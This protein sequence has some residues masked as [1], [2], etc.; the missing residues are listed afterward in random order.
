[1][2]TR[3]VQ[4]ADAFYALGDAWGEL[5]DRAEGQRVFLSLEWL[6]SWWRVFGEQDGRRLWVVVAEDD[7]GI[8]GIAPLYRQ[9]RRLLGILPYSEI[10]FLGDRYV[11]SDFLDFIVSKGKE[12]DVLRAFHDALSADRTWDRLVLDDTEQEGGNTIRFRDI[13]DGEKGRTCACPKYRCPY[14][15]LSGNWEEFKKLPDRVFKGIVA[16]E[17]RRL[18]RRHT[19]AFQF[20]APA[21]E[22]TVVL[23]RLFDLH[24]ERW[25][26]EGRKGS[27]VDKRVRE[28][29]RVA[30]AAL[31]TRG[32]LRLSTLSVDGNTVAVQHGLAYDVVHFLLET[33]WGL[34]GR[35]LK[36]GN[37]MQYLICRELLDD[38]SLHR[39]EFLRGDERYKYQWGCTDRL[40]QRVC[41]SRTARGAAGC[42]AGCTAGRTKKLLKRILVRLRR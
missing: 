21:E 15:E 17:H 35:R 36:A 20:S 25:E 12:D 19:V 33:L 14:V 34:E 6:A 41:V 40:T 11:G 29:F 8:Q 13:V 39:I 30:S 37:A 22:V 27:F 28:F 31:A 24:A 42:F 7:D 16:R 3:V 26:S 10:R 18:N 2:R 9:P 4:E 1:L 38:P 23:E 5:L 32:H